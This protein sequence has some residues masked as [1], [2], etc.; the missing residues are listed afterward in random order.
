LKSGLGVVQ[1]RWKWHHSIDRIRVPI[2]L[3]F[4]LWPHLNCIVS[5]IKW[6]AE[7]RGFLYHPYV[8]TLWRKRLFFYNRT[9]SLAYQLL[10][11]V[12]T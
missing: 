2:R 3:P 10:P 4:K 9:R 12:V 1:G 6:L 11:V 5:E 8:T 7:N